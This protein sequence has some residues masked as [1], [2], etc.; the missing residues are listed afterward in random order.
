MLLYFT[1]NTESVFTA[2]FLSLF[3]QTLTH[4]CHLWCVPSSCVWLRCG[5]SS[6]PNTPPAVSCSTRA[7]SPLS[8][9]CSSA[10]VIHTS[11]TWPQFCTD[12]EKACGASFAT[13]ITITFFCISVLEDSSWTKL[14]LIPIWL[15]LWFTRLLSTVR[16]Y[17]IQ[18]Y[19]CG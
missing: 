13:P 7:G 6:P 1:M 4:M 15:G 18:K 14:C 8:L 9:P 16:F 11:H 5:W 19:I 12:A 3:Y 17:F 2:V 10:G